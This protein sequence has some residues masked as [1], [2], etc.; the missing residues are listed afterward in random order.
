MAGLAL[1]FIRDVVAG[2]AAAVV[3]R[4]RRLEAV[5]RAVMV[6]TGSRSLDELRR[7]KVWLE[8]GFAEEVRSL[9]RLE[10]AESGVP[11]PGGARMPGPEAPLQGLRGSRPPG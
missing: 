9:R 2:G 7:A 10:G 1:P 3:A 11:E 8:P 5:F 4:I 6:L